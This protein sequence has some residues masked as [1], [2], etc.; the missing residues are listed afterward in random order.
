MEACKNER[1]S[2]QSVE[3]FD[4]D[5]VLAFREKYFNHKDDPPVLVNCTHFQI[6][7]TLY[8]FFAEYPKE[9]EA[10]SLRDLELIFNS[11]KINPLVK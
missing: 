4:L 1:Y 7:N 11:L 6:G 2:E 3:K 9:E 8:E 5:G 10:Q